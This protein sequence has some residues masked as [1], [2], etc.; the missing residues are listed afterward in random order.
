MEILQISIRT[1]LSYFILVFSLRIMGKK[2][3][4]QLN[5][6]DLIILLSIADIMIIGIENYNENWLLSLV[7]VC[8]LTL[9]QKIISFLLLK[10]A[11]IRKVIDGSISIVIL[12]GKICVEEMKKQSYNIEDLML[13]LRIKDIFDIN[14]VSLAILETNGNLSIYTKSLDEFCPIPVILSGEINDI[15]LS[16]MNKNKEFILELLGK[17]HLDKNNILCAYLKKN[18]LFVVDLIDK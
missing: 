8:L 10:R 11:K 3:I 16:I 5:L 18:H 2:E 13:Q 1:I 6:F 17:N 12:N 7:P 4:G 14:E 9:L 15:A